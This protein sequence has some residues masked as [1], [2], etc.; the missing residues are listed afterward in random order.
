MDIINFIITG[1]KYSYQIRNRRKFYFIFND[2]K[3]FTLYMIPK[4]NAFI[5]ISKTLDCVA[6]HINKV[7]DSNLITNDRRSGG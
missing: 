1:E 6:L 4:K 7:K 2:A 5:M 3:Y